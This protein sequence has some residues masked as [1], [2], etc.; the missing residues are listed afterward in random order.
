[1]IAAEWSPAM[2]VAKVYGA[3][4]EMLGCVPQGIIITVTLADG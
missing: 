2:T 1:M 4:Q 3:L